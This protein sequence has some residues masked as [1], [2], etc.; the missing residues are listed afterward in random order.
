[1]TQLAKRQHGLAASVRARHQRAIARC[2]ATS[3]ARLGLSAVLP[4][5]GTGASAPQ[6]G[7]RREEPPDGDAGG[8]HRLPLIGGSCPSGPLA[9]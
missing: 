3:V 9:K 1:M 4:P 6:P 5:A 7:R 8:L 2:S